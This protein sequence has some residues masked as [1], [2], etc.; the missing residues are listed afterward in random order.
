MHQKLNQLKL[1]RGLHLTEIM[2]LLHEK[3]TGQH[4]S[5]REGREKSV[6]QLQGKVMNPTRL[7]KLSFPQVT[8]FLVLNLMMTLTIPIEKCVLQK[9]V[10]RYRSFVASLDSTHIPRNVRVALQQ[11]EWATATGDVQALIKSGTW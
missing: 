5:R 8:S 9:I 2:A 11:L 4:T 3:T 7:Q 10:T 6:A 1:E